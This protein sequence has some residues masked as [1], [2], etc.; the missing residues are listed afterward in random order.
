SL[1][2]QFYLLFPFVFLAF[3]RGGSAKA[4][5]Q[6]AFWGLLFLCLLSAGASLWISFQDVVGEVRGERFAFF[7]VG[8]RAWQF[9]IGALISLAAHKLKGTWATRGVSAWVG[10]GMIVLAGVVFDHDTV[11]PGVAV[12]LP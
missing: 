4:A 2:E 10:L 11:F 8:T 1:E 7:N 6:R 3:W 5:K 9:G 12:F